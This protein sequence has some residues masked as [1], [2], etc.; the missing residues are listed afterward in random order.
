M[1]YDVAR[2]PTWVAVMNEISNYCPFL[3]LRIDKTLLQDLPLNTDNSDIVRKMLKFLEMDYVRQKKHLKYSPTLLLLLKILTH[4]CTFIH[5]AGSMCGNARAFARVSSL[6]VNNIFHDLMI[7]RLLAKNNLKTHKRL[8]IDYVATAILDGT[9]DN[10]LA[11]TLEF[12]LHEIL[13]VHRK[14]RAPW[15]MRYMEHETFDETKSFLQNLQQTKNVYARQK[16]RLL[17]YDIFLEK[18]SLETVCSVQQRDVEIKIPAGIGDYI[19]PRTKN[20]VLTRPSAELQTERFCFLG[21][22][23]VVIIRSKVVVGLLPTPDLV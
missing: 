11:F 5:K 10:A 14:M 22:L 16:I 18:P 17:C 15:D 13:E 1:Q 2:D 23:A 9:S 7:G 6:A 8:L 19:R 20:A 21:M 4:Q 3:R 12:C